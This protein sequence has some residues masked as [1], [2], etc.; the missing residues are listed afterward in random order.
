MELGAGEGMLM[1]TGQIECACVEERED[2]R[3]PL[4]LPM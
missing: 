4:K 3:A 1:D 2:A